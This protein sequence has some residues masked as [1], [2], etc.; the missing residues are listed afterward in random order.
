MRFNMRFKLAI[1]AGLVAAFTGC[2]GSN[3]P[4]AKNDVP[5]P[6]FPVIEPPPVVKPA[7]NKTE[8]VKPEEKPN[9]GP[10]SKPSMPPNPFTPAPGTFVPPSSPIFGGG[11]STP[12]F[13]GGAANTNPKMPMPP[14]TGGTAPLP[15]AQ[16]PPEPTKPEP[17]KPTE[18]AKPE[19]N[20]PADPPKPAEPVKEEKFEY[21]KDVGGKPVEHWLKVMSIDADSSLPLEPDAQLR[22]TAVRNLVYFGPEVRDKVVKPL[23]N[24]ITKDPDPGVQVAAITIISNMG[25][26]FRAKTKPV[27]IVL[28]NRL[29]NPETPSIV[30][31]YCVRSLA[32]FGSDA[33]GVPGVIEAVGQR[34]Q[35]KNP[36]WETRREVAIALGII[37]S[38]E[39]PKTPSDPPNPPSEEAMNVLMDNMLGDPSVGVRTE[40]VKSLLMIGPPRVKN[41]ADY[42]NAIQHFLKK[43]TPRIEFE[44]KNKKGDKAVY[45]W[46]LLLEVLYDDRSLDANVKKIAEIIKAPDDPL[47]RL[48]AL[49]ALG[50]MGPKAAK[51]VPAIVDALA[52]KEVPL[53]L[54]AMYALM[55]IGN[56]ARGAVARL[57]EVKKELP[58]IPIDAPKDY[59]PDDIVQKTAEDTID[60]ILGKKKMGD[61]KKK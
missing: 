54:T 41:P 49:Q 8:P 29:L 3:Q 60:I 58:V 14:A 30:K 51:A 25:F 24:T 43:V 37:G 2:G 18:P 61:E 6:T 34:Q 13:G 21:P 19:P 15:P 32:S 20:K 11:E 35:T 52:Y 33:R 12:S 38:P 39:A 45:V 48:A 56:S 55:N 40:V 36:S 26:D 5:T 22:E 10:S 16:K 50:A 9:A 42:Q 23:I 28:K 47:H 1:S 46:L 31:M 4:V 44:S 59:K 53:R 17:T 27:I 7:D 57:E